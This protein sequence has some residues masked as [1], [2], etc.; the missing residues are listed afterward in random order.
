MPRKTPSIFSFTTAVG[1]STKTVPYI[2]PG[3]ETWWFRVLANFGWGIENI[4]RK[5]HSK[6]YNEKEGR[7]IEDYTVEH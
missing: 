7:G 5:Q 4:G 6:L 1:K 2:N 3:F